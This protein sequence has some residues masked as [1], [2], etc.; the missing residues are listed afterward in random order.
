MTPSPAAAPGVDA[1]RLRTERA[2]MTAL[3]A[4]AALSK[5]S[6]D[7]RAKL[8]GDAS[9]R[10]LLSESLRVTDRLMPGLAA[11]VR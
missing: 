9:R 3:L 4:D 2:G 11:L 1:I 6:A 5:A 10:K 8:E 7:L